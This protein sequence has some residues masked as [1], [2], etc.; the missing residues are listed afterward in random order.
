RQDHVWNAIDSNGW[1]GMPPAP[2]EGQRE[3]ESE[4]V[5]KGDGNAPADF[6]LAPG[7]D[8]ALRASIDL[9]PRHG[10]KVV[11]FVMPEATDFRRCYSPESDRWLTEYLESLRKAH[12][13]PAVS[14]R[15]WCPDDGFR[16]PQHLTARGAERF[17]E[18]FGR[19][20][21]PTLTPGPG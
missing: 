7:A 12:H 8:R 9:C 10:A 20:V 18:R 21:L 6:S 13:V 17:T 4:T 2:S 3:K 11:L 15:E 19:E 5:L 14:A 1:L 16:D